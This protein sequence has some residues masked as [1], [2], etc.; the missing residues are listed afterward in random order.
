MSLSFLCSFN[1]LERS[2]FR[3]HVIL[4][5]LYSF[6]GL[7]HNA[8]TSISRKVLKDYKNDKLVFSLSLSLGQKR[9]LDRM[10]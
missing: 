10:P 7:G 3:H 1:E 8:P 5:F 9:T 2:F 4:S 6:I